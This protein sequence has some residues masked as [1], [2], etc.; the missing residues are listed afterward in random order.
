MRVV[1]GLGF[2]QLGVGEDDTELVVQAVQEYAKIARL[3]GSCAISG[4]RASGRGR[5]RLPAAT[6]KAVRDD[7]AAV[8]GADIRSPSG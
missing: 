8:L 5:S 6:L 1:R 2:E 3:W 4:H 7:Y